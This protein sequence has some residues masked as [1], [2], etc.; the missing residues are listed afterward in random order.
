MHRSGLMLFAAVLL[1]GCAASPERRL[2]PAERVLGTDGTTTMLFHSTLYYPTEISLRFD[3]YL[4][5]VE[6]SPREAIAA[7]GEV[8][9]R[10]IPAAGLSESDAADKFSDR[11]L[12]Y[13]SHIVENTAN[14]GGLGNCTIYNAYRQSE[15]PELTQ[16][17]PPCPGTSEAPLP[18][19]KAFSAS[20]QALERLKN[21]LDRRI[22]SS[23][24]TD[25]VVIVMGWNTV[26]EEAVRNFNSLATHLQLAAGPDFKP[27]VLGVT[28]PSQWESEWLGPVYK[29]FSF[30]VKSADADELGLSW[31]GALLH[32]TLPDLRHRL[33]ITVIGHSFGSRAASVGACIGPAIF[34]RTPEL[35]PARIANLVNL[36]GAFQV[37]RLFGDSDR[38]MHFPDACSNVDNVILTAS[39]KDNAMDTAFWGLYAG[40]ER[41]FARHCP[42][43]AKINC[44][45][46]DSHGGITPLS[47]PPK[48]HITYVDASELIRENAYLSGGGAHSD[49][50]RK[51]H[52]VLLNRLLTRRARQ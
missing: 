35:T 41:S 38:G 50:Y 3:G 19:K 46:A 33:P 6:K 18:A 15:T 47:A 13:I 29:L 9:I 23:H 17:V 44:V 40:D 34:E 43:D 37:S 5:G 32:R 21:A 14:R 25:L 27:L 11:K 49:I 4:I 24:Y 31:L 39:D 45:R 48:S 28:W 36:Q 16:I 10:A 52:G 26:Q 7:P 22:D 20:W 51:E 30:P 8:K 42:P 2:E 12:L 1:A